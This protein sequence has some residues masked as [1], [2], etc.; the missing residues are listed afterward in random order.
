MRKAIGAVQLA[1]L[2]LVQR[3]MGSVTFGMDGTG[4]GGTKYT[5]GGDS[6]GDYFGSILG[7]DWGGTGGSGGICVSFRTLGD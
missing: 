1:V 5:L 4:N 6:Y 2:N 3:A 7:D